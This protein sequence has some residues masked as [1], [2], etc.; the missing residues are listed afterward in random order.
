LRP[1]DWRAGYY[2]DQTLVLA[3]GGAT[4]RQMFAQLY[5]DADV[6]REPASG[7][8]QMNNHFATRLLDESGDWLSQINRVNS[9]AGYGAVAVQMAAALGLAYASRLYRSSP[10]LSRCAPKFSAGGEEV[11]AVSIGN[12]SAAEGIFFETLNAAAVLQVPLVVSVWDDGYG[13]SVPNE[14][15]VAKQSVSAALK[16]LEAADGVPGIQ[17]HVVPGW[18]YPALLNAYEKAI[19]LSRKSHVPALVH[20]TE[21][22]Q[23]HG[24]STSGSH[25]RYKSGVRLS[26]EAEHDCLALMRRW[27]LEAKLIDERALEALEAADRSVVEAERDAAWESWIESIAADAG[28]LTGA[29]EGIDPE[30]RGAANSALKWCKEPT[31]YSRR[32]IQTR[33]DAVARAVRGERGPGV[34]A[35]IREAS[36]HRRNNQRR[37]RSHLY[38]ESRH[39]PLQVPEVKPIY[40]DEPERIDGRLLLLR[41]FDLKLNEDPRL[42]ILGEDVGRLGDVNLVFEGLQQKYGELRVTDTG[43][44]E[45]T[46][47]G[48][49]IGAALRGLRPIVDI[50]YI[51]YFLFALEVASDDLATLHYRTAGG[52]K[53]PVI[54]RTKGHRL[55]G[56]THS[57]SPMALLLH[58]CRGVY[59]CVPRD[60]TRAA[61]MYA[62]LLAGDNPGIVIEVLNGY[63]LKETVP[64]NLGE[65]T[66]PLGVPEVV[67]PGTD[68]TVVTY[69]PLC[70]I[71][72]EAADL[73]SELEIEIEL[74]DVQ[75]LNPFD[76]NQSIV[77]SLRKTGAI[78]FLDEDVPG[79]ATAY[80]LRE[81]IEVQGGYQYLDSAPATLSA[82]E[83]RPAYD[84]DGDYFTK[85]SSDEVVA[86]VY[87]MMSERRPHSF[88]PL[89]LG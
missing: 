87:A 14:L 82:S 32:S 42:L 7:G 36:A 66:V 11:V 48:Q 81:V 67:R 78:L 22:T 84:I 59:I 9:A 30:F 60:M 19:R 27:I 29:I 47:L 56:M 41:F 15:Q 31:E 24:H 3:T 74:I 5:G 79:G 50:Q 86:K 37:F 6:S 83:N 52:Q 70:R 62:T 68:V 61:G 57:G 54:V 38:S 13:I 18:D 20:V 73:L 58:A 72:L 4:L 33:F 28:G 63:R 44:R 12:A 89:E 17:I 85:P 53:A 25:E 80:M 26:W 64:M 23:P 76:T 1:G 46:I 2:R 21:L 40:S 77:E 39:S 69:G 71:A 43:I 55:V 34:E 45:A 35:F 16:G 51:D 88:P 8:R 75:T 65:M 10:P 49:G